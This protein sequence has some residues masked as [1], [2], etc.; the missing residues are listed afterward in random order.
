MKMI[1]LNLLNPFHVNFCANW[2]NLAWRV[3]NGR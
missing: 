3:R 1:W 2:H